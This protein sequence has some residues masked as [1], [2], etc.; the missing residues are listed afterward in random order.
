MIFSALVEYAEQ[1][2]LTKDLNYQPLRVRWLITI[3]PEGKMIGDILDTRR[4]PESGKGRPIIPERQVPKRS[5]RTGQDSSE[6][7]VDKPELVLVRLAESGIDALSGEK[8]LAKIAE[9]EERARVRHALFCAEVRLAAQRSEDEGL[10]A[11]VK[12]LEGELPAIPEQMEEGDLVGFLFKRKLQPPEF[13]TDRPK[14]REYWSRRRNE[15]GCGLG[16]FT[17]P[18]EKAPVQKV[19][20]ANC[21]ISG[22]ECSPIRLHP[23]IKKIPGT[24]GDVQLTSVNQPAFWSYGLEEVGCAPVSQEA[25]DAYESALNHL[26]ADERR[27]AKVSGNCAVVYWSRG[28]AEFISA[29][30]NEGD[31][32]KIRELMA[33]TWKGQQIHLDDVTPFYALAISGAQGRG[34]VRGWH[35]T[36][37]G[38]VLANLK[39]WFE[40]IEIIRSEKD[41]GRARPLLVLL[42]QLAA[43]GDLENI[44]TDLASEMFLD[45]IAGR[46]FP[47]AIL[48]T[49]V[50]RIRAERTIFSERAALLKAY[51]CRARRAGDLNIPEVCPMLDKNCREIGYR[52]GRLFAVLEKVQDEAIGA[53]ASI[54]DRY[55]GA[56][57]ATPGVVYPMLMRKLPHH[58][59]KIGKEAQGR[60][61]YFEKLIQEV[62]EA[63]APPTPFP[64]VLSLEQQGL[65][66]IGFYHQTQDFYIK[67]EKTETST[68]EPTQ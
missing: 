24:S 25:A 18:D 30:M 52:L 47:V 40:D 51:L 60:E 44:P 49:L 53:N 34:T 62:C 29:T 15:G 57:S 64:V 9:R 56:A 38:V 68:Q 19:N 10:A 59:S 67:R 8:R 28:D 45:I 35:E 63:I 22:K 41:Q 32:E 58:L 5:K 48:S 12:F 16:Q 21:L 43:Q 26:L 66:A 31:P 37:L 61:I 23:K 7:I 55:Y 39:E 46:A 3:D 65:F 1:Q 4:P 2:E 14:V 50:R 17:P 6:F 27:C 13:L 20:T 42:R 54:R 36:T 33:S 11:L